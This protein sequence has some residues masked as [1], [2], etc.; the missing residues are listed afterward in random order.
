M[1][2]SIIIKKI[3]SINQILL[4]TYGRKRRIES[5]PTDELILTILS[6]NTNDINRDRAF[7]ELKRIFPS[8]HKVAAARTSKIAEAIHAGGLAT[9]KSKRLRTILNQIRERAPDYSLTFL[10][11]MTDNEVREYLLSFTGVGP[12]TAACVLLFS[13]GRKVMPVDTHVH[14]VGLRLGIIPK[15]YNAD[16]AHEW[17]RELNLQVDIQQLHL[18]LI[19]HGRT[20]CRPHNPKCEICP[21][22][23]YCLY[24]RNLR[25]KS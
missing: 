15:G 10:K 20:L 1:H 12:K 14:R 11:N 17:F 2:K 9:I 8:W 4:K 24:F 18:N 25:S 5:A 22:R 21:L 6:Q 3:K 7:T 16:K 19:A 23:R 13:L